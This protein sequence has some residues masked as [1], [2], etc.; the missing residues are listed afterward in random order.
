[1]AKKG[2][3]E[4]LMIGLRGSVVSIILLILGSIIGFSNISDKF[5]S[6]GNIML[7]VGAIIVAL[8]VKGYFLLN[9][10]HFVFGRRK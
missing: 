2:F 10:E 6:Q 1:M 3:I 4:T 7:G 5:F 8:Y 9:F